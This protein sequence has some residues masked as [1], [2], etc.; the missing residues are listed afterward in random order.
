MAF[1]PNL[2]LNVEDFKSVYKKKNPDLENSCS[3][4]PSMIKEK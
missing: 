2:N 1:I 4:L 3:E